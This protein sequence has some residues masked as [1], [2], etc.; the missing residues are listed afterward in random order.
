MVWWCL[1]YTDTEWRR[2]RVCPRVV[3]GRH[4]GT[5]EYGLFFIFNALVAKFQLSYRSRFIDASKPNQSTRYNLNVLVYYDDRYSLFA[6]ETSIK[7][8]LNRLASP[9]CATD[10]FVLYILVTSNAS[11]LSKT[12][13]RRLVF[14]EYLK[15]MITVDGLILNSIKPVCDSPESLIHRS[16]TC[17]HYHLKKIQMT[18]T[19]LNCVCNSERRWQK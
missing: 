5:S 11:L 15:K 16:K 13:L 12:G 2:R 10:L 17:S 14:I 8:F 18:L 9:M 1:I 7:S 4:S 19:T 6:T 3:G